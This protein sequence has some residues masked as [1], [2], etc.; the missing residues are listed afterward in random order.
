MLGPRVSGD[1][2]GSLR[3]GIDQGYRLLHGRKH[4]GHM[5]DGC[6]ARN[7]HLQGGG[8][9]ELSLVVVR[10]TSVGVVCILGVI[11][12]TYP[13]RLLRWWADD[14]HHRW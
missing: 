7:H 11:A 5:G 10:V 12:G 8:V 3:N 4:W 2:E 9:A 13:V 14:L 1:L 6:L